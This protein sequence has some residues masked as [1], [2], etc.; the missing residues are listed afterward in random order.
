MVIVHV[1]G[2]CDVNARVQHHRSQSL[3]R[4]PVHRQRTGIGAPARWP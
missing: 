4:G 3:G 2:L 1:L